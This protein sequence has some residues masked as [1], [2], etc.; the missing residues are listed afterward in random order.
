M[1]Y[2]V[3]N[4]CSKEDTS[5]NLETRI[6]RLGEC[7]FALPE[8]NRELLFYTC[9]LLATLAKNSAPSPWRPFGPERQTN[10]TPARGEYSPI[11]AA[12]TLPPFCSAHMQERHRRRRRRNAVPLTHHRDLATLFQ[13]RLL[14]PP[15]WQTP[16]QREQRR[17]IKVLTFMIE[18][19]QPLLEDRVAR[20]TAQ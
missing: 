4:V 11:P 14:A 13:P 10:M 15:Q 2:E 16:D 5:I 3:L 20:L 7:I 6:L 12:V 17:S 8:V 18:R 19:L 1:F 9:D